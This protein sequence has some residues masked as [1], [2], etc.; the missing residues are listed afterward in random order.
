MRNKEMI[1]ILI[2]ALPFIITLAVLDV[3]LLDEPKISVYKFY[4]LIVVIVVL[5]SIIISMTN[6]KESGKPKLIEGKTK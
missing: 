1:I 5:L 4:G 3:L 6:N 2:L